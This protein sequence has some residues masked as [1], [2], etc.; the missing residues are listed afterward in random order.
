[1]ILKCHFSVCVCVSVL[2]M[3]V[4]AHGLFMQPEGG[5]QLQGLAAKTRLNIKVAFV[6]KSPNHV[7]IHI[8]KLLS[9]STEL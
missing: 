2:E 4:V 1:M 8:E 3:G 7:R 5:Y 9:C 6:V